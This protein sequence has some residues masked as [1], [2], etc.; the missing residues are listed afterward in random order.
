MNTS[1]PVKV[2][3]SVTFELANE[4]DFEAVNR[5]ARQVEAHHAQ[6]DPTLQP[7]EHPYPMDFFRQCIK[8]ESI[9]ENAIYVMRQGGAVVGYM[10]IYLWNTN[11]FVSAKRTILSID[12]LGV[13]E[14]LRHRGIGTQM[15]TRLADLAKNEWGCHSIRL[16]VDAPNESAQ[17]YYKKCGFHVRNLGMALEL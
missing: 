2:E 6:W 1:E 7:T 12:D 10:R 15:M 16:Y 14:S 5:L 17:A 4:Q 9:R 3:T 11:S 8:P 13:E